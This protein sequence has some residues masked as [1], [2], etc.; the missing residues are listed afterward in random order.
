MADFLQ[1][2]AH[3]PPEKR[4][5]AEIAGMLRGRARELARRA[6]EKKLDVK[7]VLMLMICKG[8]YCW[9]PLKAEFDES[10]HKEPGSWVDIESVLNFLES[11]EERAPGQAGPF[12]DQLLPHIQQMQAVPG[13]AAGGVAFAGIMGMGG[14]VAVHPFVMPAPFMANQPAGLPMPMPTPV[15]TT[16]AASGPAM[17]QLVL[18]VVCLAQRAE[19]SNFEPKVELF[20]N[21]I[22]DRMVPQSP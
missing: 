18:H 19:G 16:T 2:H 17:Q 15:L 6:R 14:P 22:L 20:W 5:E 7:K 9:N 12:Y 10:D 21:G 8:I 1:R 3:K 4:A 13:G 11:R